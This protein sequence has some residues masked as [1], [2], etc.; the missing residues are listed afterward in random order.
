MEKPSYY[1]ILPAIVRYDKNL[2]QFAKLIYAEITALSNKEGYC[3]ANNFYFANLYE[4]TVRT[5]QRALNDLEKQQYIY[6]ENHKDKGRLIFIGQTKLSSTHDK[7]VIP[8]NDK[9]VVHNTIKDNTKKQYIYQR[10]LLD[11]EKF[12]SKLRGRKVAKPSALNLHKNLTDYS[13]AEKKSSVLIHRSGSKT[14]V[15]MMR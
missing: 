7:N 8:P 5:V 11:F 15:G 2:S 1:A 10:D 3:W 4:T 14:R 13:I 9:N 12:W 6:K